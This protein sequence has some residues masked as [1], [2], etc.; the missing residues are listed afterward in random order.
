VASQEQIITDKNTK[1]QTEFGGYHRSVSVSP[2]VIEFWTDPG[3]SNIFLENYSISQ[4]ELNGGELRVTVSGDAYETVVTD[5][6]IKQK[7]N[8]DL[9]PKNGKHPDSKT[10]TIRL[11]LAK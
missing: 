7:V 6:T 3:Y 4:V 2:K 8:V 11:V 5:Q 10:L 9:S 1:L